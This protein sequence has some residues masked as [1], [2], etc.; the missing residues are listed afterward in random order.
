MKNND[1]KYLI[2]AG[3]LVVIGWASIF[4]V[5]RVICGI[6]AWYLCTCLEKDTKISK[7]IEIFAIIEIVIAFISIVTSIIK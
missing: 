2:P 3:I 1:K 5:I 4:P 7:I 6:I